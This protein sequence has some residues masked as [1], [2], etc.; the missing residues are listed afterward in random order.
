MLFGFQGPCF[1]IYLGFDTETKLIDL[2]F[3]LKSVHYREKKV[4]QANYIFQKNFFS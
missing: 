3:K 4:E 1:N 2:R